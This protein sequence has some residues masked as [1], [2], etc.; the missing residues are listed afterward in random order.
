MCRS[1]NLVVCAALT[2]FLNLN[3]DLFHACWQWWHGLRCEHVEGQPIEDGQISCLTTSH[4][5]SGTSPGSTLEFGLCLCLCLRWFVMRGKHCSFA[6]KYYRSSAAE[7]DG[8]SEGFVIGRFKWL[9]PHPFHCPASR[10][11]DSMEFFFL[12]LRSF[13]KSSITSIDIV[14]QVFDDFH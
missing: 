5:Q 11:P 3:T 9:A 10:K 14:V 7:H 8:Y 1:R 13:E 12:S 4:G 6:E 2:W